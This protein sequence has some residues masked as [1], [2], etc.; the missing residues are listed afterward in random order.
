VRKGNRDQVRNPGQTR[1]ESPARPG[2]SGGADG[3]V[4]SDNGPQGN[5]D[6]NRP[7]SRPRRQD[8]DE[9]S[10]LGNRNTM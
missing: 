6:M 1:K 4:S 5:A 9:E 7:A 8:D 10:G 3:Q 2:T